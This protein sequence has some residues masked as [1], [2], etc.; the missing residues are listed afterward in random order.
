MPLYDGG[1]W[2]RSG[3]DPVPAVAALRN[4]LPAAG[5]DGDVTD[6]RRTRFEQTYL[7]HGPAMLAYA[8]R[9]TD[10]ETAQDVIAEAFV[11]VWRRLESLPDEPLPWLYGIT[12]RTL[13]NQRRGQRRRGLLQARLESDEPAERHEGDGKVIAALASLGQSD[14]ELLTLIAWEGLTP[15]EAA[16]VIGCSANACRI[17]LHRARRK[18]GRALEANENR[19]WPV[20][21]RRGEAE[22]TD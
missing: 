4:D 3:E 2:L 13:A 21:A 9:R 17:R 22:W 19:P 11:V 15:T 18:L 7:E 10:S 12:R 6:E 5:H 1:D 16:I 20:A 14:R 8:L